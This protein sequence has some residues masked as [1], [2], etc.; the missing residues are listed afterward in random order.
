VRTPDGRVEI[1]D[2][3]RLAGRGAYLCADGSC[4]RQAAERGT[5]QRALEAKLPEELKTRLLA[6]AGVP[7]SGPPTESPIEISAEP[8][9][10]STSSARIT[11]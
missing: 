7:V 11:E 9:H 10:S 1:D 8:Q 4:W 2:T 6:G 3:G 5:L